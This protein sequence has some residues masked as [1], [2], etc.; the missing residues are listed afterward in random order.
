MTLDRHA[1]LAFALVAMPLV[2]TWHLELI[3]P[4]TTLT[5][6]RISSGFLQFSGAGA[7]RLYHLL[8][9]ATLAINLLAAYILVA[10]NG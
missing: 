6:G 8:M 10:D 1:L 4:V 9:Y 7:Y 2:Y 5:A 3:F